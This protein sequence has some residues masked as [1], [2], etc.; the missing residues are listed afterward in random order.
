[1]KF[2]RI[3]VKHLN[4]ESPDL[5]SKMTDKSFT[6]FLD[7]PLPDVYHKCLSEQK[8]TL[9]NYEVMKHNLFAFNSLSLYNFR[10]DEHTLGQYVASK[11]KFGIS[12]FDVIGTLDMNRLIMSNDFKL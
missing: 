12:E 10:V 1:M 5:I 6:L 3:K 8:I 11:M 9:S 7:I 4:V 2:I